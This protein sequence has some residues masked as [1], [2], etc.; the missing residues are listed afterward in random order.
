MGAARLVPTPAEL[1]P[2]WKTAWPWLFWVSWGVWLAASDLR[3][4][5]L[6]SG[7]MRMMVGAAVLA[8][9]RPRR[10]WAWSLSLLAWT[11]AMPLAALAV[12]TVPGPRFT[13][14][15]WL[16]APLPAFVGGYLGR[17]IAA[18]VALKAPPEPREPHE[19]Q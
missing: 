1:K 7:L 16:L 11:T 14:G 4:D 19:P 9:A 8:A 6:S 18:A 2:V 13:P 10:W 17:M 12:H 3:D 5:G 15:E